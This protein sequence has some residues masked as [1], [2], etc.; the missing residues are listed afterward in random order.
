MLIN[1]IIQMKR[2]KHIPAVAQTLFI[3]CLV[4]WIIFVCIIISMDSLA[5]LLLGYIAFDLARLFHTP[6]LIILL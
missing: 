5:K 1:T 6:Y 3:I 2:Y 4:N